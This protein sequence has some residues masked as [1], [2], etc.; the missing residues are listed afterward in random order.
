[1]FEFG[2]GPTEIDYGANDPA[3]FSMSNTSNIIGV[4]N[5]YIKAGYPA[6]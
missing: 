1:M 4:R 6:K 5:S 2:T 3:T